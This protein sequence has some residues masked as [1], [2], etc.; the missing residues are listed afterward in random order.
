MRAV[1]GKGS[2]WFWVWAWHVRQ[3]WSCFPGVLPRRW[4]S[5][6][7]ENHSPT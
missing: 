7:P 1:G 5:R 4:G 3:G 2:P 6:E